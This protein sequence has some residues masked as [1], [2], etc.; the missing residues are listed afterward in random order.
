MSKI[1]E[2]IVWSFC[3]LDSTQHIE[4]I[5][6]LLMHLVTI[7]F[8]EDEYFALFSDEFIEKLVIYSQI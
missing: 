1:F 7:I 2:N 5:E 3:W 4:L 8:D 6:D